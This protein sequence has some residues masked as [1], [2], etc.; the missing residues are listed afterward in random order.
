MKPILALLVGACFV[1][2]LGRPVLSQDAAVHTG[3]VVEL[4]TSQGCNACPP[5][6]AFVGELVKRNDVIALTFNVDYWDYLGWRDT[7]ASPAHT[8]RQRSYAE[9]MHERRVYTPQSVIGGR[10]QAV[11]SDRRSIEQAIQQLQREATAP[12]RIGLAREGN[13][14][15]VSLPEGVPPVEAKIWLVR[16]DRVQEV[17]IRRGENGGRTLK[18]YNVVREL[19]N[20]GLW[21]GEAMEIAYMQEDL[22]KGGRDGCAVIVQQDGHGPIL[23]AAAM[24]F[25]P[26]S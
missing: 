23:G 12:L 15:L 17:A 6:D 4:F 10:L 21:R 1:L 13:K 22:T 2:A 25:T 8:E 18:Y 26:P 20:V 11:G 19:T 9:A 7:L 16:Y 3:I 5:A 14:V 24:D